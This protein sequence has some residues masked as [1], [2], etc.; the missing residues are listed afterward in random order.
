[1]A[2]I[3]SLLGEMM[4]LVGDL[5]ALVAAGAGLLA[6]IGERR[7][8][9]NHYLRQI[10]SNGIVA[11][12]LGAVGLVAK[13]TTTEIVAEPNGHFIGLSNGAAGGLLLVGAVLLSIAYW[14]RQQEQVL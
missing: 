1:M 9:S 4:V 10:W 8:W 13:L 14:L 12:V 5:L 7:G 2:T 3:W 11:T 6:I